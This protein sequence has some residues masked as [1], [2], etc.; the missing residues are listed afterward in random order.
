[1]IFVF[2]FTSNDFWPWKIEEREREREKE[3]EDR[4]RRSKKIAS[5]QDDCTAPIVQTHPRW[6]QSPIIEIVS[7]FPDHAWRERQRE[8]EERRSHQSDSNVARSCLRHTISPLPPL[9]DLAFSSIDRTESPLSLPSS[10]NLTG[11]D[12]FFCWV[13]FL[14]WVSVEL[15]HFPHVYSWGS[16]WKIGWLGYVKHFP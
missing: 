1:M 9:H 8:K 12:E 16:V 2:I 15:I 14:L 3:Q 6:T 4:R 5:E 7:P 10:L 13:L 11:F